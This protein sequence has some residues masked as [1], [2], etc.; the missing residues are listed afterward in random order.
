MSP[1]VLSIVSRMAL[2]VMHATSAVDPPLTPSS[3]CEA[4]CV[5][6][7]YGNRPVTS[8]VS[9]TAENVGAPLALPWS[10]V[11]V[12]PSEPMTVG[13]APAP[14]PSTSAFAVSA[15]LLVMVQDAVKAG[16]PPD[17]P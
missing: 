9:D 11:V 10:S 7:A 6:F 14:P 1:C 5:K 8:A 13:A 3:V 2:G 12:V 17:V 16:M 4:H 15:A